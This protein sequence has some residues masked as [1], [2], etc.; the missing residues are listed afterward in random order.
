MTDTNEVRR[1]NLRRLVNEHEGM[2]HL[3]KRLGLGRGAYISQLLTTPPVRKIS[4]KTARKWERMLRL[5]EGWLDSHTAEGVVAPLNAQLL[6]AVISE[7]H[8][9]LRVAKVTLP[10]PQVADLIVLQYKD[11][12]PVGRI[13]PERIRGIVALLKR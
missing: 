6:A 12:L 5:P 9:A 13:D 1:Q 4:E 8:Q 7:V 2:T 10:D 11:A 3:A